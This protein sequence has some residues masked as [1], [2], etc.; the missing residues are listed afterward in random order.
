MLCPAKTVT[1]HLSGNDTL[2]FYRFTASGGGPYTMSLSVRNTDLAGGSG[3][4]PNRRRR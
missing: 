3:F 1:D 2:D 4:T